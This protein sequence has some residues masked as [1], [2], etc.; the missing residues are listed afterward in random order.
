M[1]ARPVLS[2]SRAP[3]RFMSLAVLAMGG[4]IGDVPARQGW[5]SAHLYNLLLGTMPGF[6]RK[7]ILPGW[8]KEY[9][10]LLSLLTSIEGTVDVPPPASG[11]KCS[12]M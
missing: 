10:H 12:I 8:L 6:V 2:S 5:A 9:Q 4:P 3:G 7:L 1:C 11:C